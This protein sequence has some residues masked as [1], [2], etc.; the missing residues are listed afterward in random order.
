MTGLAFVVVYNFSN[1]FVYGCAG[2]P[3][4]PAGSL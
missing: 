4:L 1:L 3:R 2:P